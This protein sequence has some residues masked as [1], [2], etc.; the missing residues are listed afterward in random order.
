VVRRVVHESGSELTVADD[1]E[2]GD[3]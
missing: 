2:Q 1:N 3:G